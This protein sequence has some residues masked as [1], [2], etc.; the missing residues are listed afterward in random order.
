MNESLIKGPRRRFLAPRSK[1]SAPCTTN[2]QIC[3]AARR[4]S[5]FGGPG[6]NPARSMLPY[7]RP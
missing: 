3:R 1:N 6:F 5:T 2:S 7:S 4:I